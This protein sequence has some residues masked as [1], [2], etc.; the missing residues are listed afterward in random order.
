MK[1]LKIFVIGAII[2]GM[3]ACK[4]AQLTTMDA[5]HDD[6]AIMI[7]EALATNNYGTDNI[8]QNICNNALIL[9]SKGSAFCGLSITDSAMYKS[10]PGKTFSYNYKTNFTNKLN[11][12]TAGLPDN[13][14]GKLNYSGYFTGPQL[15]SNYN[16]NRTY[17]ITGLSSTSENHVINGEYKCYNNYKFKT[18]TTNKGTANIYFGIKDLIVSKVNHS[19]TSGSAMIMITGSS[20]KKA[21]YTYNGTLTFYP[22]SAI[23]KLNGDEYHIDI[24]SGK[25]VK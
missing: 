8:N 7:A 12:S 3:T 11:C 13:I 5:P 18:D 25:V 17:R 10:V 19:I 16:G 20:T 9:T 2:A 15:I 22:T 21:N 14:T 6:A 24:T 4:K 1:F 23:L